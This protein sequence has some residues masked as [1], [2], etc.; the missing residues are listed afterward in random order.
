VLDGHVEI[1]GGYIGGHIRLENAKADR[2]DR[3]LK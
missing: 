2:K 1:D 3:C